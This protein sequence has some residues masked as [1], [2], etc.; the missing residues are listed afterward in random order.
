[1]DVIYWSCQDM[2][3]LT[4]RFIASDDSRVPPRTTLTSSDSRLLDRMT[5]P[6][7]RQMRLTEDSIM[8]DVFC[9]E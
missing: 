7:R 5:S 4:I 1:M 3:T 8:E 9:A 6:R 2:F